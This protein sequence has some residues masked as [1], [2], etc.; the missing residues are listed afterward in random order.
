MCDPG[1]GACSTGDPVECLADECHAAGTCDLDTGICTKPPIDKLGCN[2]N[3]RFDGVADMGGGKYVAIFGYDSSA[4]NSF[5]PNE[6]TVLL[7]GLPDDN[8]IPPQPAY[9]LPGTH[10]G[11]FLLTCSEGQAVTWKV[12]GKTVDTSCSQGNAAL[13]TPQPVGT[14]SEVVI[15]DGTTVMIAPDLSSYLKTPTSPVALPEPTETGPTGKSFNGMLTGQLGVSPTGAATYAVPIQIPPGIAG[16]APN[17]NLVYNSQSGQGIAGQGWDMTGLSTISRCR[18]THPQDGYAQSVRM[19][20]TPITDTSGDGVCLDG[21]RLFPKKASDG[22]TTFDTEFKDFSKIVVPSSGAPFTVTTKSGETRYYGSTA[23]SRV[24]LWQQDESGKSS[25]TQAVVA[26]WALDK[27]MDPWGNYYEIHYNDNKQDFTTRGLIVTEI[28][29][30]GNAAA[31]S[32]DDD[33]GKPFNTIT[34]AYKDRDKPRS[35]RFGN[36]T[37]PVNQLLT[38]ITVGGLG[39]YHLEYVLG[40]TRKDLLDSDRLTAI[41]FA[42]PTDALT[43]FDPENIHSTNHDGCVVPLTFDWDVRDPSAGNWWSSSAGYAL[44]TTVPG[45]GTQFVDLDGDGRLDLVQA[46]K[47]SATNGVWHNNGH[48]WDSMGSTWALPSGVYLAD[49]KGQPQSTFFM[50]VDGDGLSDLIATKDSGW[51]WV[52]YLNRLDTNRYPD[53]KWVQP[54]GSL[55]GLANLQ[56]PGSVGNWNIGDVDGDG[57]LDLVV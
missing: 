54:S 32:P 30:T 21:K 17:L 29:Y 40:G 22:S 41:A 33:T 11:A 7:N 3:L 26:I 36:S 47:G 28:D 15:S 34:F 46:K 9:L 25:S 19:T 45:A 44:P 49:D 14:G 2:I 42:P 6:N 57:W 39:I 5:H 20:A 1:T 50:D 23:K 35:L 55:A 4:T 24:Y 31:L 43:C 48:G 18:K 51:T 53:G 8:P 16:M 56:P 12:D 10:P 27:V 13:L 52:V 38:E 37:V